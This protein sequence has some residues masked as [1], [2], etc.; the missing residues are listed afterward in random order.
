MAVMKVIKTNTKVG[1][2]IFQQWVNL[3]IYQFFTWGPIH[4]LTPLVHM[5]INNPAPHISRVVHCLQDVHCNV[6]CALCTR[7]EPQSPL[8][9]TALWIEL[10]TRCELYYADALH[11][12]LDVQITHYTNDTVQ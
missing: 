11:C 9:H 8:F 12:V 1:Q 2:K 10:Y 4:L 6:H 7:C 5:P 3:A